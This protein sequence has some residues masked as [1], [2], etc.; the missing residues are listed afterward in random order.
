VNVLPLLDELIL[1]FQE[2]ADYSTQDGEVQRMLARA[3]HPL[4]RLRRRLLD[5][6]NGCV[7]AV[8][9]R[10]NVG[11]ST[12]L[13]ALLGEEVAPQG[14]YPCTAVP[15]EYRFGDIRSITQHIQDDFKR[16]CESFERPA[17]LAAHLAKLVDERHVARGKT[18]LEK[19]VVTLPLALLQEGLVLVDT[20]GF[21]AAQ[22]EDA[23]GTH[24][25][26]LQN[27]LSS[28]ASQVFW[29]VRADVMPGSRE[30]AFYTSH[31]MNVCDDIIVT[32]AEDFALPDQ[33]RW[34]ERVE[35]H[36]AAQP[37]FHF[38][39]GRDGLAARKADDVDKLEAAGI[40]ALENRIRGLSTVEG[41]SLETMAAV[42]ELVRDLCRWLRE[43]SQAKKA[44]AFSWRPD[45][46]WRFQAAAARGKWAAPA[47]SGLYDLAKG[48]R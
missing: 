44:T 9:G 48:A 23:S 1:L 18:P 4:M 32:N 24:Q 16:L 39:S 26:A 7:L 19:V 41:R 10:T 29:V 33:R 40:I 6:K 38:V 36:F 20:P 37:R 21:G 5:A 43:H 8:V 22:V 11:K 17:D 27:Y 12:L 15:V 47:L 30:F 46:M 2:T 31:L 14:N 25:L 13:N 34:R 42:D 28:H 3:N 45:S 35:G